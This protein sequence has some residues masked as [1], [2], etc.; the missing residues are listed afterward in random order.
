M[1]RELWTIIGGGIALAVALVASAHAV[2]HKRDVRA[3]LGWVALIWFAPVA[4]AVAYAVLGVNRIR[5]RAQALRLPDVRER[6]EDLPPPPHLPEEAEH[7]RALVRLADAIVRRPLVAGNAVEILEG[8]A[9]AYPAMLEA[10]DRA[11]RSVTFCTYIFDPGAAGD[12]FVEALARAHDRGVHVRVLIDAIGARYRWPP[13]YRRLRRRGVAT[14][15]FL[16]RLTPAWLPFVNLRNHRKLLVVD[17]RVGFTG[18]MNVRDEFLA[19]DGLPPSVDVQVRIEGPVVAHLQSAFAEDWLFTAGEPLEGEG[20]FPPLPAAG[21]VL[22]RGVADGPDEDFET[23]RW[24]LLGALSAARR[25]VRIV[26]PYFLPDATLVTALN[27]AA[28]RGVE[29]DLVLPL[30]SNLPVV[31]WAQ[32]AQ[33]WQ[34]IE[35]GCRVWLT[36]P[37]FDHTKAMTVDGAWALLGSANWDPRSLRLNFEFDVEA[38]DADLAARVDALVDARVAVAHLLTLGE[39]DRR[40][41]ALRLR[42]GVARLLSPYL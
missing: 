27:V 26:T 28:L 4:G 21:P 20:F 32:T 35:R 25:R 2:L 38:Y 5:R 3:A 7:L 30:I 18:G 15:L 22:A 41:L 33:L 6:P 11:E 37:P 23:I 31:Q 8:G 34:V 36:P 39:V 29:V 10:I 24:L 9:R 42:D 16:P 14:E 19:A 1:A 12:A 13:L 40:P 17:G